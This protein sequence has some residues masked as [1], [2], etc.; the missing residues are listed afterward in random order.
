V[1]LAV[2]P[3]RR[4]W[5]CFHPLTP[6]SLPAG[7]TTPKPRAAPQIDK[8]FAAAEQ[9]AAA[10]EE[11]TPLLEEATHLAREITPLLQASACGEG[12]RGAPVCATHPS[13]AGVCVRVAHSP[14]HLRT[15]GS[16]YC[17]LLRAECSRCWSRLPFPDTR[18]RHPCALP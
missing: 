6:S 16:C 3:M 15:A 8:I 14:T 17:E 10:L 13:L 5:R 9:A 7:A 2:G 4:A 18:R 12:H 1:P 11:A